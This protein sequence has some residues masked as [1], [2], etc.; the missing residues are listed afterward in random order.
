MSDEARDPIGRLLVFGVN[1]RSATPAMRERLLV[2]E[3]DS[4]PFLIEVKEQG[5]DEAMVLATCDRLEVVALHETP[6]AMAGPLRR[7]FA[8]HAQCAAEDIEP[9]SYLHTGEAALRYLFS[10]SASL[11]SQVIGE[12]QVLGQ[13]K[14]SHRLAAGAGVLGAGLES[15][16]QA[17]YAVAKRVRRETSIGER[18]VSMAASALAVARNLHGDLRRCS[19]LLVGLGEMGEYMAVEFKDAGIA[20]VTVVHASEARAE[21]TAHRLRGHFRPWAELAQAIGDADIVITAVGSGRRS[22]TTDSAETALRQRRR[23]PI[24]F[25]DTAVPGD[26][27]PAVGELD[28][29]FLYDLEDLERLAQ[30]GR[31]TREAG[32]AM[33]WQVLGEELDVYLRRRAERAGAPVITALRRH[34]ETVRD[35]VLR[36]GGLD[37]ES[38][39]RLLIKRLLHGPSERLRSV[40]AAEP[41]AGRE[42][43]RTIGRL[44]ALEPGKPDPDRDPGE[45]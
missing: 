8:A 40:T 45:E 23:R 43:E 17:A 18:P 27:E 36:H 1:H 25:V 15:I 30:E 32:A 4:L 34:F 38:A 2:E 39:T 12:P 16:L 7:I 21:A 6:E 37:A 14:E 24:F 26:V 42:L 20:A 9:Q 35:E 3:Q 41:E 22:V 13:V 11:D 28:G 44:F 33:A 5:L 10:V 31:A 29:A 19:A